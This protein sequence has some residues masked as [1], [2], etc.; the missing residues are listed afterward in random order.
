V[1]KAIQAYADE[2]GTIKRIADHS[3]GKILGV[4]Y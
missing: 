3:F 2:L 1:T 4:P